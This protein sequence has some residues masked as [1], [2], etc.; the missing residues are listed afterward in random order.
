MEL[1]TLKCH[2][3]AILEPFLQLL[4]PYAP[5]I[6]EELWAKM[7]HIQ[8]IHIAAFPTWDE[9]YLTEDNFEYPVSINGKMRTKLSLP[10]D[11]SPAEIEQRALAD[12]TVRRWMADKAPKKVIVVPKKIIN[13][14]V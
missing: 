2:K 9:Q 10:I 13:V 8:S 11:L 7:G 5:H 6:T 1:N 14:V 12:E 4:A 3:Q